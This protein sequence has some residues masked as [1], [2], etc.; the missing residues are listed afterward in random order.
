MCLTGTEMKLMANR[1]CVKEHAHHQPHMEREESRV[2]QLATAK[3][4]LLY[5]MKI[6]FSHCQLKPIS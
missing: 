6:G 5:R 1:G 2:S 4:G 3:L